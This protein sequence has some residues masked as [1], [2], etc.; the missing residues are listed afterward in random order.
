M[1]KSGGMEQRYA[2]DQS[3]DILMMLNDL[4]SR[5]QCAS[6]NRRGRAGSGLEEGGGRGVVWSGEEW[7]GV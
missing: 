3:Y 5:E 4:S 2:L 6:A 1:G 7:S